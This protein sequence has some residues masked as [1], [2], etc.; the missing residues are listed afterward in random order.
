M[1][2]I[3]SPRSS[4]KST[5][6]RSLSQ[7]RR[8]RRSARC[9]YH[10]NYDDLRWIENHLDAAAQAIARGLTEYFGLPF[11]YPQLVRTGIVTT[12]GA[13]LRLRSTPG[14]DGTII[15]EIPNGASVQIYGSFQGW[16]SVGY[17]GQ[18]GYA[19]QAY[20]AE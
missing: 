7:R 3:F 15:A 11:L 1:P 4:K 16:Y 8:P 5:R 2:P 18:L 17:G 9:G 19:A 6:C 20:I 14:I 10:D 13:P 12:E